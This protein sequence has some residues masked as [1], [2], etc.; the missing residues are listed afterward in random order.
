MALRNSTNFSSSLRTNNHRS[1]ATG[2]TF[3]DRSIVVFQ[4]NANDRTRSHT[5]H[6]WIKR[7]RNIPFRNADQLYK[8]VIHILQKDSDTFGSQPSKT[9]SI[10]IALVENDKNQL[11]YV[12]T[13]NDQSDLLLG[14]TLQRGQGI[15]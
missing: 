10:Y 7:I 9:L 5:R 4:L 14:K 2:E 1:D 3:A 12:A 15:S 8:E 6:Q 11:R 13:S